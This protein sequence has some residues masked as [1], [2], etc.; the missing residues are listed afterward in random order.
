MNRAA[1]CLAS[2]LALLLVACADRADDDD[3]SIAPATS[4]TA[5]GGQ[6]SAPSGDV[7]SDAQPITIVGARDS[8]KTVGPLDD[9]PWWIDISHSGS[10]NF[11]V[12]AD[13]GAG[14]RELLVNVVGDYRGRRWLPGGTSYNL[15]IQ[16]DGGWTVVLRPV[17]PQPAVETSLSG[18]GDLVTGYFE[19]QDTSPKTWNFLNDGEANFAVS[20]HCDNGSELLQNEVGTVSASRVI[21]IP[22]GARWCFWEV[23]GHEGTWSFAPQ[24]APN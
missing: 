18:R 17:G 11:A 3:S 5:S 1:L 23:I 15:E 10:S 12:W 20:L 6:A 2:L 16:A 19:P 13:A 24:D 21:D 7:G 9:G 8:T 4:P 14:D 22:E